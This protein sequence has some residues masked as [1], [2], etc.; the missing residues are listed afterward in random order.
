M[1]S[2]VGA[3]SRGSSRTWRRTGQLVGQLFSSRRVLLRTIE[4]GFMRCRHAESRSETCP[5]RFTR[6]WPGVRVPHRPQEKS[7]GNRGFSVSERLLAHGSRR[8]ARRWH[9]HSPKSCRSDIDLTRLR[10][11][12]VHQGFRATSDHACRRSTTGH[13]PPRTAS[14]RRDRRPGSGSR[15]G[16]CRT[17]LTS[18]TRH[19]A[20]THR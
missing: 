3:C 16:R 11:A 14:G 6:R 17:C 1:R 9:E 13:P 10:K 4:P 15:R 18:S 5:P 7:P 2:G 19:V 20:C 12:S 8:L